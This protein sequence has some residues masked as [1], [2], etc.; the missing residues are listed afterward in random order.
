[1]Q[2]ALKIIFDG[3]KVL[4]MH[5]ENT[6]EGR[7]GSAG[8]LGRATFS[9]KFLTF[10]RGPLFAHLTWDIVEEAAYLSKVFQADFTTVTRAMAAVNNFR[11][12]LMKMKKTNCPRRLVRTNMADSHVFRSSHIIALLLL[13][14]ILSAGRLSFEDGFCSTTTPNLKFGMHGQP[15]EALTAYFILDPTWD[16]FRHDSKVY[17][18]K[19]YLRARVSRYPNSASTFQISR[20]IISGDIAE[21]P[22]PTSNKQSCPKNSKTQNAHVQH[23]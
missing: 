1:M 22:R 16:N 6:K 12:R 15:V 4:V 3:Y 13:G 2:T 18:V 17:R 10:L 11:L 5:S 7:V 8:R 21:N 23:L 14:I 9:A 20:L 19:G